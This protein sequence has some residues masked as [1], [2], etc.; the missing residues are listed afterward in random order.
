MDFR[1][2]HGVNCHVV[3]NMVECSCE[4]SIRDEDGHLPFSGV[5]YQATEDEDDLTCLKTKDVAIPSRPKI[6]QN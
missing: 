6:L 2:V 4:V 3:K 5:F 1:G